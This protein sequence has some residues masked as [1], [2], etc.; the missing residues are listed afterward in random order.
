MFNII[1]LSYSILAWKQ[2]ID[3]IVFLK[4][5]GSCICKRLDIQAHAVKTQVAALSHVPD[6]MLI[7]GADTL[8]NEK[9]RMKVWTSWKGLSLWAEDNLSLE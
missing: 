1:S 9:Q 7:N 4:G 8:R 2:D 6:L 3:S 5:T